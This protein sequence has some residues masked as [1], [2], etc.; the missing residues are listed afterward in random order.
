MNQPDALNQ[1]PH[2]HVLVC[3]AKLVAMFIQSL[4]DQDPFSCL[5]SIQGSIEVFAA[6]AA[7]PIEIAIAQSM[8]SM[9]EEMMR[10]NT[11]LHHPHGHA[12]RSFIKRTQNPTF[13][14]QRLRKP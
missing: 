2:H 7:T 5:L 10:R 12:A 8:R 4:E 9:S 13:R 11:N 14:F 6:Q 3:G 1:I